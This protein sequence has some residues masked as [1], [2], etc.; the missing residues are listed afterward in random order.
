MKALKKFVAAAAGVPLLLLAACGGDGSTAEVAGDWDGVVSAAAD[1]GKVTL[2]S[3]QAVF[4]MEDLEKAFEDKYPDID[5]EVVRAVDTDIITKVEAEKSTGRG[6]ADVIVVTDAN[7]IE[8]N[9]D[10]D[11]LGEV[12]GPSFE[13][14]AYR[15]DESLKGKFF[16]QSAIVYGLGWNKELFPD[17]LKTPEDLLDP[18][19][20]GKIGVVDPAA[21]A[22]LAD[23]YVHLEKHYGDDYLEKL[24]KFKPRI[25]PST[26]PTGQAIASGELAAALITGP[27]LPEKEAGAPVDWTRGEK[28]WGARWYGAVTDASPNPNAGQL[29][30]DFL[31][32]SDG[33]AITSQGYGSTLPDI[34][35]SLAVAQ[36]LPEQNIEATSGEAGKAYLARWDSIFK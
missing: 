3:S 36:D 10:G 5:L 21:S 16:L 24:A 4:I 17:G 35:G 25:Y 20:E 12:V 18:R 33:Q 19:L 7:W 34:E 6:L 1:E 8:D 28:P 15:P 31:V 14:D 27:M 9:K 23:Y 30:A 22:T 32:S 2:Y 13:V 11:V 26:Q 29:L